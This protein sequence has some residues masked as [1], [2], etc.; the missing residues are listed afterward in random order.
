M[1]KEKS[2]PFH[3]TEKDMGRIYILAS[4]VVNRSDGAEYRLAEFFYQRF[5][6]TKDEIK[7]RAKEIE[8]EDRSRAKRMI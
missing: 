1:D 7:L 8:K 3:L 2:Y 4:A 5:F 6:P